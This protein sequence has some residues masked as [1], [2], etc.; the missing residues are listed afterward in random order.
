[1]CILAR[2]GLGEF[3]CVRVIGGGAAGAAAEHLVELIGGFFLLEV[4][5]VVDLGVAGF[6]GGAVL[7]G[8]LDIA[9]ERRLRQTGWSRA[10]L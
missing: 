1:M 10:V 6:L 4:S 2:D 8:F 5:L 9:R 7:E 3:H